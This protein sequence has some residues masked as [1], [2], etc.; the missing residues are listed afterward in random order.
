MEKLIKTSSLLILALFFACSNYTSNPNSST[1]PSSGT[2]VEKGNVFNGA[3]SD[4]NT[5]AEILLADNYLLKVSKGNPDPITPS[6]PLSLPQTYSIKT[7]VKLTGVPY[8]GQTVDVACDQNEPANR[9]DTVLSGT[10]SNGVAVLYG[11]NTDG[12]F[13]SYGSGPYTI[14]GRED[15]IEHVSIFAG[16]TDIAYTFNC[17]G[18]DGND[19][20]V[21]FHGNYDHSH[22]QVGSVFDMQDMTFVGA[23]EIGLKNHNDTPVVVFFNK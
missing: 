14:Q 23:V 22:L 16:A 20:N 19:Y 1:D 5:K 18:S 10:L 13:Y 9:I 4:G 15:E 2:S 21:I 6:V 11:M 7:N 17:V 8:L 3:S 12:V